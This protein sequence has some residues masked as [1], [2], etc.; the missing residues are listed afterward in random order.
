MKSAYLAKEIASW[1]R[2]ERSENKS[3]INQ[4]GLSKNKPESH[5]R[6]NWQ[7]RPNKYDGGEKN[8]LGWE[9]TAELVKS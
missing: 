9:L 6:Q 1:Q 8:M 3:V 7:K 5:Q 2:P 4:E